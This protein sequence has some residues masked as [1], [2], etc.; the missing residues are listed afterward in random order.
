MNEHADKE[1]YPRL[2]LVDLYAK[3]VSSD[4]SDE[5]VACANV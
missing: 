1:I 3:G 4:V 5:N 2:E